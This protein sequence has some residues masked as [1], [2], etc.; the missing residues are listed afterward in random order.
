[1][2]KDKETPLELVRKWFRADHRV[3]QWLDDLHDEGEVPFPDYCP[4]PISAGMAVLTVSLG[5][6]A[7]RAAEEAAELVACWS[8]RKNKVIYQFDRDLEDMLVE[9]IYD[10]RA[11]D[12]LPVDL[13]LHPPYPVIYIKVRREYRFPNADGFFFWIEYDTNTEIP[14]ARIQW[15]E[16]DFSKSYPYALHLIPGGTI[17]DST[18]EFFNMIEAN[19]KKKKYPDKLD[20]ISSLLPELQALQLVLYLLAANA[21]VANSQPAPPRKKRPGRIMDAAKEIDVF[22]VGVR[23]GAAI[24]K[25]KDGV[26]ETTTGTATGT[27][28]KHRPH[29]RRGHW[30]HYWTGPRTGERNLILKWVA[31]TFIHMDETGPDDERVVLFPVKE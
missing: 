21:D 23:I 5:K 30:H 18:K 31:P 2:I 24:R 20:P 8:W 10:L 1:M 16:G 17:Y 11:D 13:L 26:R 6:T 25:N 22:D 7:R 3:W 15:V 14:E 27:G 4:I 19:A 12:S 9:Q 28:G 29:P